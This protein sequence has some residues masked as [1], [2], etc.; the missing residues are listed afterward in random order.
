MP[1]FDAEAGIARG[2]VSLVGAGPGDPGLV[3][4]RGLELV[5]GAEVLVYDRLIPP[6]LVDLAPEDC[7]RVDVGKYPGRVRLPQ[8]EINRL[9]VERA[10]AGKRV[11]RLKGGDPFVFG[12]GG[13]EAEACARAGVRFQVV[14][15]VTSAIAGPAYAGIPVTHPELAAAFAVVTGQERPDRPETSVDW[16][17][18]AQVGTVCVLM[19]VGSLERVAVR[20]LAAGRAPA[21]PAVLVERATMPSQRVIRS[22]LGEVAHDAGAAGVSAP[23]MLVVGEVAALAG[24]TGWVRPRRLA[25]QVVLVP[26]D[27]G[28]APAPGEYGQ[29]AA[30]AGLLRERGAEPLELPLVEMRPA[31]S[32]AALDRAVAALAA[33]AYRW[34]ALTSRDGVEALRDR[35][36]AAGL[37]VRALARTRVAAAGPAT[38]AALRAWGIVP[39]LLPAAGSDDQSLAAAFPPPSAPARG[40]G[41]EGGRPGAAGVA[42]TAGPCPAPAVLL[43]RG[44]PAGPELA[45]TLRSKGWAVAEVVAYRTVPRDLDPDLRKRVDAGEVGWV[46]FTSATAVAGF[47][48]A[49]GGPPPPGMRVAVLGPGAAEAAASCGVR[50]DALAPQH[51][52][53]PGLVAA[54]EGATEPR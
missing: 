29:V 16:R 8:A 40:S 13:E 9:L 26:G 14:P 21:T 47:L 37:D 1:L 23:A 49:Y 28:Q 2:V 4:V 27:P 34:T 11:V 22:T 53:V 5:T 43:P 30:L 33:G 32:P 17:A 50:V 52:T 3:T 36:E 20:L 15:G 18:L 7:E 24:R 48:G 19:T 10:R 44:D 42:G 6:G 54:I 41:A 51:N 39:D 45:A 12:R 25:G 35:V 31:P 38:E 46:A